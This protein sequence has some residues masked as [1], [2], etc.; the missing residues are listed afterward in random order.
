MV[1]A[2]P[3]VGEVRPGQARKTLDA[4]PQIVIAHLGCSGACAQQKAPVHLEDEGTE[5]NR[6]T[7]TIYPNVGALQVWAGSLAER[8]TTAR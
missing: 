1:A 3:V 8:Q 7:T 6:G 5:P 2:C 4:F